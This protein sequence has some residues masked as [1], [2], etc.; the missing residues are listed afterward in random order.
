M[1]SPTPPLLI[2]PP[3]PPT[4]GGT[5]TFAFVEFE[6]ARDAED[7]VRDRDGYK[8]DG[9]RLRVEISRGSAFNSGGGGGGGGA[10]RGPPQRSEYRVR[11]T[12]VGGLW[13]G[14]WV[15]VCRVCCVLGKSQ[16]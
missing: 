4:P 12:G 8:F 6:D 16:L 13:Q 10:G 1:A 5:V 14:A 9:V 3:P 2:P 7:A 11:G 15:A